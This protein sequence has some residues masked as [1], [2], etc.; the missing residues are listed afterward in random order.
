MEDIWFQKGKAPPC[1]FWD[2]RGELRVVVYGDGFAMLGHE[3]QLNLF[4]GE[5]KECFECKHRGPIGSDQLMQTRTNEVI[6]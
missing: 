2:T 4:K 3:E 1:A 5:M 6:E